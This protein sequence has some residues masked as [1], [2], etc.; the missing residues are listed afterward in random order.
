MLRQNIGLHILR[1]SP[2]ENEMRIF[3][4]GWRAGVRS[5]YRFFIILAAFLAIRFLNLTI[6]QYHWVNILA[7]IN[8]FPHPKVFGFII[9]LLVNHHTTTTAAFRKSFPHPPPPLK[10][11]GF[12]RTVELKIPGATI[13]SILKMRL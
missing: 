2:Y 13:L 12:V 1:K 4:N 11:E 10:R 7:T 3:L 9:N 6:L 5:V 8:T